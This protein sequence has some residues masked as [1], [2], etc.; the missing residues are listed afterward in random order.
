MKIVRNIV[1]KVSHHS[2]TQGRLYYSSHNFE[3][4]K[5]DALSTPSPKR[6][7]QFLQK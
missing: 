2:K 7:K 4:G 5:L 3:G 1:I 6:T